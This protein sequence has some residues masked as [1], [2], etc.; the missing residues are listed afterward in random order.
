[1]SDS[2]TLLALCFSD[3]GCANGTREAEGMKCKVVNDADVWYTAKVDISQ[4]KS[5]LVIDG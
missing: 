5:N 1:M 2:D 4:K 3:A